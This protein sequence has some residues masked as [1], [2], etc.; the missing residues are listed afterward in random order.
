MVTESITK[1]VSESED[2][3]YLTIKSLISH[4]DLCMLAKTD[5][6]DLMKNKQLYGDFNPKYPYPSAPTEK[7]F[8]VD[9]L[10]YKTSIDMSYHRLTTKIKIY[11]DK[12]L[13]TNTGFTALDML[14][15]NL[16]WDLQL[17]FRIQKF[18]NKLLSADLYL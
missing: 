7:T 14:G 10:R 6:F 4:E 3:I 9:E 16:G 15:A 8:L 13:Y 2:C 1:T 18:N 11:G 12:L 17:K 5:M